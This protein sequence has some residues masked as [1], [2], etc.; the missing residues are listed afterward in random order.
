MMSSVQNSKKRVFRGVGWKGRFLT[1]PV[2]SNIASGVSFQISVREQYLMKK[3][4]VVDA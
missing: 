1:F 2:K 3:G 4:Y